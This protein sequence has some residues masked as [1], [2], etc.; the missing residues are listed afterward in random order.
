MFLLF[1][2]PFLDSGDTCPVAHSP[3]LANREQTL[4]D[5]QEGGCL[6]GVPVGP[7]LPA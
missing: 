2:A 3:H 5:D 6:M 7:S 1:M 4:W